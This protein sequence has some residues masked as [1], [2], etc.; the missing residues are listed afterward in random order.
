[1]ERNSRL[2]FDEEGISYIPAKNE[3]KEDIVEV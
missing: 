1:M 2:S 3:K